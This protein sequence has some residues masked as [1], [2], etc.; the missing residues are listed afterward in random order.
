VANCVWV[1]LYIFVTEASNETAERNVTFF[2]LKRS[3][4]IEWNVDIGMKPACSGKLSQSRVSRATNSMKSTFNDHKIWD[5]DTERKNDF[6]HGKF[7]SRF[8]II[9]FRNTI[10][11]RS[12]L[13]IMYCL[14]RDSPVRP[15]ERCGD[16]LDW[17]LLMCR[18]DDK[19]S[20]CGCVLS[21]QNISVY[22]QGTGNHRRV[23]GSLL[24]A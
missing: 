14:S 8:Y 15:E 22:W 20:E 13:A 11:A 1:L 2:I 24:F 16:C 7:S 18:G 17:A 5:V 23:G 9:S 3:V 21:V 6:F 19:V 4:K 10:T 12:C